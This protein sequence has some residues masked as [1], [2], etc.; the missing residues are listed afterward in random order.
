M[1]KHQEYASWIKKRSLRECK[2]DNLAIAKRG[3]VRT[4]AEY[5][6][7]YQR[8]HFSSNLFS[9]RFRLSA[10]VF[11]ILLKTWDHPE[12]IR[13]KITT[14]YPLLNEAIPVERAYLDDCETS[15]PN[16]LMTQCH[17]G[18]SSLVHFEWLNGSSV[19]RLNG[20]LLNSFNS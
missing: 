14:Y 10:R 12:K 20:K 15:V 17:Y 3:E 11:R 6:A 9:A 16:L 2:V 13:K 18:P 19:I 7:L 8:V 4:E 1:Q 5:S